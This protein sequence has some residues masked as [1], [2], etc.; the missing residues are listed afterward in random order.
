MNEIKKLE[1][2][3]ALT[4]S[5]FGASLTALYSSKVN[6]SVMKEV[7]GFIDSFE[8]SNQSFLASTDTLEDTLNTFEPAKVPAAEPIESTPQVVTENTDTSDSTSDQTVSTDSIDSDNSEDTSLDT[9]KQTRP[10][11]SVQFTAASNFLDKLNDTKSFLKE[12]NRSKKTDLLSKRLNYDFD[13]KKDDLAAIG[14]TRDGGGQFKISEADFE[15]AMENDSDHVKDT[16]SGT[17]G[18]ATKLSSRIES[19]SNE[20]VSGF[21]YDDARE[22]SSPYKQDSYTSSSDDFNRDTFSQQ[23]QLESIMQKGSILNMLI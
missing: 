11:S 3:D 6:S 7:S 12:N 18:F 13:Q 16:L 22:L 19:A 21:A 2:S 1:G 20:P 8:K 9:E 10:E 15:K 23:L 5:L 4:Q 14:I 17:D